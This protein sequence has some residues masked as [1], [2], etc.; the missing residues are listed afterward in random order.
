MPEV[1][2]PT[3]KP[4]VHVPLLPTNSSPERQ[5][6][7]QPDIVPQLRTELGL[8][9]SSKPELRL[10]RPRPL[11]VRSLDDNASLLGSAVGSLALMWVIYE[12]ILPFSGTLGFVICWFVAFLVIY[13][14]VTS[15][16]YPR[17]MVIDRIA[18][19][20]ITSGAAVV[21]FALAWTIVWIFLQGL[22][23]LVHLNFYTEDMAGVGLNDPLTKGGI[24]HAIIGTAIQV[25]IATAIALPLGLGT[26]IYMTEVNSR[27]SR[28]VRTVVEAMTALPDIL[29][30][31]FVFA[32][33]II[34]LSWDRSGL[35]AS[36][37][38]A[39]TMMPIIARSAEV[40]LRVVPGGLREASLALGASQWATLSR[41]VLP[42]AKAGMAT[43]LIL[44][45]ARIA[46]ET[47]PL[48]IVSGASSF[49]NAN[50]TSEPMNSLPLFIYDAVRRPDGLT[51]QARGYGA[52]TL[53]LLM[54]LVLFVITR[55]LARDKGSSR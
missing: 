45:I 15:M 31:L 53:L 23:A 28:A 27:V 33:L 19:A 25:A 22:T 2:P 39:V 3:P 1:T 46:G 5:V 20:V 52:A 38:L 50:P 10:E 24:S 34:A 37:A 17:P 7:P 32:V 6:A 35:A 48:L 16:S 14:A 43:S 47:A 55:F 36:L 9:D 51:I 12:R 41:V 54:V 21:G 40:V 13:S 4:A 44:G 26:A 18:A 42:T 8:D 11:H 49:L 29:A 30:G